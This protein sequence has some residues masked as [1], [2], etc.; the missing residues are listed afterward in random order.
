MKKQSWRDGA[1][2]GSLIHA[3][4]TLLTG[5]I[6]IFN[7]DVA[8]GLVFL[9][10]PLVFS[11]EVLLGL[12]YISMNVSF[13]AGLL[14]SNLLWAVLGRLAESRR[15]LLVLITVSLAYASV[16]IA[17]LIGAYQLELR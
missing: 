3:G 7:P 8:M 15:Y 1:F 11:L 2:A 5:L 4:L 14:L 12:L 9:F 13:V 6:F 16:F 10:S 17:G